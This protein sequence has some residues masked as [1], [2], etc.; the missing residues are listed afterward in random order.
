MPKVP[1]YDQNALASSQVGTAGVD[2]SAGQMLSTISNE[3][4]QANQGFKQLYAQDYQTQQAEIKRKQAEVRAA[5][6]A[7]ET[8]KRAAEVSGH[9]SGLGVEAETV[10]AKLQLAGM[11]NTDTT[12]TDFANNLEALKQK[13]LDSIQDPLTKLQAE[14]AFNDTIGQY[15]ARMGEFVKSRA[16]PIIGANIKGMESDLETKLSNSSIGD[17]NSVD[18]EMQNF[19]K[20]SAPLYAFTKG[21]EGRKDLRAAQNSAMQQRI[22]DIANKTPDALNGIEDNPVV[23]KYTDPNTFH[24]F[25]KDQRLVA[26]QQRQA[27]ALEAKSV[28]TANNLSANQKLLDLSSDGDP[29]SITHKDFQ[30]FK[31]SSDWEYLTTAEK[32]QV[33][34]A[35]KRHDEY[36]QAKS[37]RDAKLNA[38]TSAP[39]QDKTLLTRFGS[40][41]NYTN[42]LGNDLQRDYSNLVKNDKRFTPQDEARLQRKMDQYKTALRTIDGISKSVTTPT[43]KQ[44]VAQQMSGVQRINQNIDSYLRNSSNALAESNNKQAIRNKV[45]G[46]K[47]TP[48][49]YSSDPRK[50]AMFNFYFNNRFEERYAEYKKQ[51]KLADLYNNKT[52]K[53]RNGKMVGAAQALYWELRQYAGAQVEGAWNGR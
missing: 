46:G 30:N 50:T 28:A 17:W 24:A 3:A 45:F 42:T 40:Y 26:A 18:K 29:R 16:I 51:G 52:V 41:V 47:A 14:K 38:V 49:A 15:N 4:D 31:A 44:I 8:A 23:Q 7:M 48:D 32:K 33:M 6:Q 53:D 11:W 19:E 27:A 1:R 22:A 36:M 21:E 10:M 13:K 5:E 20:S 43:A 25:L 2:T 34:E 37:V 35:N 9:N 12:Q 39:A